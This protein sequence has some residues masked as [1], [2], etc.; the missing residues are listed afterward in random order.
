MKLDLSKLLSSP[1]R[2][3]KYDVTFDMESVEHYG[4][5]YA[6]K[7]TEPFSV[8][9][10][11]A[12]GK[13]LFVSGMTMVTLS[14]P[15]DRCLKEVTVHF[16]IEISETFEIA[17]EQ[18]VTDSDENE[19]LADNRC[20]DID[21]LVYDQMQMNWPEKVLCRVDCKGLCPVCGHDLNDGD[22]GCNRTVL[23]PR[24]AKFLDVFKESN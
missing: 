16:P 7:K 14:I 8:T 13:N 2:K 5:S 21:R 10:E 11:N 18:I 4:G 1:D 12:G 24:M 15:C 20:L 6:V 9:A 3:E 23:D 22:C 17:D 19:D